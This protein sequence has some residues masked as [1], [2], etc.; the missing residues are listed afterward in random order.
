[1]VAPNYDRF[2]VALVPSPVRIHGRSQ[3]LSAGRV[4]R[5]TLDARAR[6]NCGAK[7]RLMRRGTP[8]HSFAF[9]MM[10]LDGCDLQTLPPVARRTSSQISAS[11]A[12]TVVV[13]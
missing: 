7:R 13:V 12:L 1:V 9:E 10:W 2:F 11:G 4:G 5:G 3:Y 8:Q 6:E